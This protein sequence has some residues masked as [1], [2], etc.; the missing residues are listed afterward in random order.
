MEELPLNQVASR[1]R[2]WGLAVHDF[3][4]FSDGELQRYFA[5]DPATGAGARHSTVEFLRL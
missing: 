5:Q 2:A 1:V 3:H 4:D